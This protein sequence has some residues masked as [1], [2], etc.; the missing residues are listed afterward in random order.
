MFNEILLR[1]YR[2]FLDKSGHKINWI[3]QY[4]GFDDGVALSLDDKR[5]EQSV[6]ASLFSEEGRLELEQLYLTLI[7]EM[8]GVPYEHCS[9]ILE[10]LM[11]LQ[12]ISAVALWKYHQ[13][14]GE[15]MELFVRDFDRLDVP[16][17]RVR[18]YKIAQE[19]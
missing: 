7:S 9:G 1:V 8:K 2:L 13:N 6:Y 19:H 15:K 17:E 14:V 10:A 18:L 4:L 16:S 3:E 12:E 5:N 11:F